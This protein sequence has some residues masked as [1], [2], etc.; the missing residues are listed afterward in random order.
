M[1]NRLLV[2]QSSNAANRG[3]LR[4]SVWRIEAISLVND[5]IKRLNLQDEATRQSLAAAMDGGHRLTLYR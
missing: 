4:L 2:C 5:E 3:C 1:G